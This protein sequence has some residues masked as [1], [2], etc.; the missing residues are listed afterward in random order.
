MWLLESPGQIGSEVILKWIRSGR[1]GMHHVAC[2]HDY[3]A[4]KIS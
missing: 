4:V 3:S 1:G 2:A